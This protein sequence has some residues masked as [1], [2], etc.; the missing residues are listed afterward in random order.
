MKVFKNLFKKKDKKE[1]KEEK[2]EK[3]R[4]EKKKEWIMEIKEREQDYYIF[5]NTAGLYI[6][7]FFHLVE[8]YFLISR[9]SGVSGDDMLSKCKSVIFCKKALE[10]NEIIDYR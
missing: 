9:N 10:L 5:L 4:K 7:I 6:F 8:S 2:K 1:I 3:E